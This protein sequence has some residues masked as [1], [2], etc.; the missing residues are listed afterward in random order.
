MH[1]HASYGT[2]TRRKLRR[3]DGYNLSNPIVVREM[4]DQEFSAWKRSLYNVLQFEGI[5]TDGITVSCTTDEVDRLRTTLAVETRTGETHH[6][7][8]ANGNFVKMGP[9]TPPREER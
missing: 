6:L 9:V 1:G 4:N 3:L 2:I 5:D 7:I 8:W